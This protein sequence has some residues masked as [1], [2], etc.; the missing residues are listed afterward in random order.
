MKKLI[1]S[2]LAT[3]AFVAGSALA[4]PLDGFTGSSVDVNITVANGIATLHGH[5][6]SNLDR[7][8]A[9]IAAERIAD[10]EE[11]RNLITFSR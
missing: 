10:V 4:A 6:E 7:V 9:E 1:T 8:M 2:S 5:V 11:V 3:T